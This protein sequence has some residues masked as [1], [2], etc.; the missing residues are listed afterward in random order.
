MSLFGPVE[1]GRQDEDEYAAWDTEGAQ[2]T[3]R[4][5]SLLV[6]LASLSLSDNP[7]T[8][9]DTQLIHQ[10]FDH[11]SE[12]SETDMPLHAADASAQ[13]PAASPEFEQELKANVCELGRRARETRTLTWQRERIR[14]LVSLPPSTDAARMWTV[15]ASKIIST[16]SH[17]DMCITDM[18]SALADLET[19]IHNVVE[20]LRAEIT[21]I[22][23]KLDTNYSWLRE[24]S[25]LLG[26]QATSAVRCPVCL[27]NTV[28]HFNDPCGHTF[29][30]TCMSAW[31]AA[32]CCICRET[33]RNRRKLFNVS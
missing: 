25:T 19:C 13:D 15:S 18:E 33:I 8:V 31:K 27:I 30:T 10:A 32:D 12:T 21:P 24:R 3:A 23:C 4:N 20:R 16:V 22:E 6:N 1:P 2:D 7:A 11:E 28:S 5:I 9:V 17:T 14:D 26:L 29:C